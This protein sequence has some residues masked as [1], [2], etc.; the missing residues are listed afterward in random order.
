MGPFEILM[1][2][3]LLLHALLMAGSFLLGILEQSLINADLIGRRFALLDRTLRLR[4]A[5]RVL[6]GVHVQLDVLCQYCLHLRFQTMLHTKL[7][8]QTVQVVLLEYLDLSCVPLIKLHLHSK[9]LFAPI[10][11]TWCFLLLLPRRVV[12]LQ[13]VRSCFNVSLP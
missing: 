7:L 13:L 3:V 1:F 8:S 2:A 11:V 9:Y 6:Y 12:L 4:T 10:F 5:Q